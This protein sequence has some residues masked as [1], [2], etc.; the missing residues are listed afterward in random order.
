M[1]KPNLADSN[2]HLRI[3][4]HTI[5]TELDIKAQAILAEAKA[6]LKNDIATRK[7]SVFSD[8]D[9][10]GSP[11]VAEVEMLDL[12]SLRISECTA[13]SPTKSRN[14]GA[15]ATSS[16]KEG[17][18]TDIRKH[19]NSSRHV[20]ARNAIPDNLCVGIDI[21]TRDDI[22]SETRQQLYD[23]SLLSNRSAPSENNSTGDI[24]SSKP[25]TPGFSEASSM[26]TGDDCLKSQV[27]FLKCQLR[28]ARQQIQRI[29]YECKSK[30]D[31]LAEVDTRMAKVTEDNYILR[32]RIRSMK[33][34]MDTNKFVNG[35]ANIR[36]NDFENDINRIN[37]ELKLSQMDNVKLVSANKS[38][39]T[40]LHGTIKDLETSKTVICN[41]KSK[42]AEEVRLST[43]EFES[44]R[45][46][47]TKL[48][49]QKGD[50][51]TA[52]VKQLEL[53]TLYKRQ[54]THIEAAKKLSICEDEF[55]DILK[56]TE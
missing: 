34:E 42:H 10:L 39:E 23:Q 3:D 17:G 8:F 48:E 50:L 36:A 20:S 56:L 51:M 35:E 33:G 41:L 16:S 37:E 2:T 53:I 45:L 40:R 55:N 1:S 38:I 49:D 13:N 31:S 26:P 11:R 32:Q 22:R 30:D 15:P 21:R 46:E 24:V 4:L 5:K 6:E 54:K 44:L 27:V 47:N 12:Q 14:I 7:L 52:F 25:S 28:E 19:R 43:K 18:V 29:T 9:K